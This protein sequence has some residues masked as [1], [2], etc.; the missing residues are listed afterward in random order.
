MNEYVSKKGRCNKVLK[1]D[2]TY[3]S[4]VSHLDRTVRS[5]QRHSGKVEFNPARVASIREDR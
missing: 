5:L 2:R 3:Y 4:T 1:V